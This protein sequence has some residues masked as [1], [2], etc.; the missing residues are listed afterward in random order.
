MSTSKHFDRSCISK[1]GASLSYRS[2]QP[3]SAYPQEQYIRR[4]NDTTKTRS[5][6]STGIPQKPSNDHHLFGLRQRPSDHVHSLPWPLNLSSSHQQ[7]ERQGPHNSRQGS[8]NENLPALLPPSYQTDQT[9]SSWP[10]REYHYPEIEFRSSSRED[11]GHQ[12]FHGDGFYNFPPQQDVLEEDDF[13]YS[14]A[15]GSHRSQQHKSVGGI[16]DKSPGEICR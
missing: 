5:Y 13:D 3:D 16:I 8:L 11:E 12:G 6:F 10:Q 15:G 9:P 7:S 14:Y 4:N 2:P 1:D